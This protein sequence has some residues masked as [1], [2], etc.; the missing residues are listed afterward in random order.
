MEEHDELF[1]RYFELGLIGMAV[2]APRKG[3]LEVNDEICKIL[4][5]E[6]RELLRMNWE[7]LTHPDDLA[8]DVAQFNRVMT[9]RIDGYSL[10]KR[11][12]R[13]DG[14]VVH[15]TISVGCLRLANGSVD[16]FVTL[17]QDITERK[18]AE[19][20]RREA[21]LKSQ[22]QLQD[23]TT[24]LIEAQETQSKHLARELHDVLSQKLA[25]IGI[26]L[27]NLSQEPG[28]RGDAT[29]RLLTDEVSVLATDI[30][31]LSRQLHPAIV[32]DL[33]LPAAIK[34]ECLLFSEK[35][36]IPAAF[37]E[38]DVPVA[39]PPEV[40]LCLYRVVQESLRNVGK[41]ARASSVEVILRGSPNDLWLIVQDRGDGFNF[42]DMKGKPRLG[43]V[44]MEERVRIVG[45]AF[46]I[47]SQPGKGTRVQARVPLRADAS[48][49]RAS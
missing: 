48:G 20:A 7:Q 40:A 15:T 8:T 22:Q 1:R 2:T 29:L 35:Y 33:G 32:D 13:K 45:G 46:S 44:S 34:S 25:A 19:E 16:R 10:D 36:N 39:I 30:H 11:W 24:R 17:F 21:L 42:D 41:H 28:D 43:L 23:L 37:K 4:G 12:M 27:S 6:R 18:H 9:G 14:S 31:R 3:I 5:Y 47:T 26:Q 38:F 49:S